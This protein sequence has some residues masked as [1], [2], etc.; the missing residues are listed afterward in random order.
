M[1][2]PLQRKVALQNCQLS[3]WHYSL[4]TS[5]MFGGYL[6]YLGPWSLDQESLMHAQTV[7]TRLLQRQQKMQARD[8]SPSDGFSTFSQRIGWRKDE[9]TTKDAWLLNHSYRSQVAS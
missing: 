1:V 7:D 3:S 6:S 9:R 2:P 8:P 5:Y 4:P